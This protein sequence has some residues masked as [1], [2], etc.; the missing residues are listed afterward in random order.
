MSFWKKLFGG[1]TDAA[2]TAQAPQPAATPKPTAVAKTTSTAQGGHSTPSAGGA[3]DMLAAEKALQAAVQSRP[4]NL[5]PGSKVP[6]TGT[7]YCEGCGQGELAKR[8]VLMGGPQAVAGRL[9]QAKVQTK[10]T[11]QVGETFPSCPNCTS[12]G[13]DLTG[14]SLDATEQMAEQLLQ[15]PA[16]RRMLG[17]GGDEKS[18]TKESSSQR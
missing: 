14:W 8:M 15:N 2:P 1:G 4:V 10:R 12:Y 5:P 9:Q 13:G 17:L 11:F 7:Y 3:Q 6:A 18:D 16:I